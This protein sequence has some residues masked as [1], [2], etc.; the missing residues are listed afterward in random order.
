MVPTVLTR[1]DRG[2]DLIDPAL[3]D[4]LVGDVR[5]GYGHDHQT[6]S[7]IVDQALVYLV[8]CARTRESIGPSPLVDRGWH[9]FI[10]RTAAY[11][12][13][14]ETVLGTFIDHYPNDTRPDAARQEAVAVRTLEAVRATGLHVD[15]AV[16]SL[17]V[18]CGGC[19]GTKTGGDGDG[20]HKGCHDSQAR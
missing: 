17:Q 12:D 19:S 16:W 3:F 2:R 6:A 4:R 14:C 9:A 8:A 11:R 15:T 18:P 5:D 7:R 13:F 1:A 20:C 10:L